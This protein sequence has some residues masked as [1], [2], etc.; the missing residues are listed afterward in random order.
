MLVSCSLTVFRC[1]SLAGEAIQDSPGGQGS[2]AR[3]DPKG[4]LL[5]RPISGHYFDS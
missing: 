4:V 5:A 2:K 3:E 1:L